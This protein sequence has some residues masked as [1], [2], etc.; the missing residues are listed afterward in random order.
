MFG[1]LELTRLLAKS[2]GNHI[3]AHPHG[4]LPF[5]ETKC[6]MESLTAA[7]R[8]RFADAVMVLGPW[9]PLEEVGPGAEEQGTG[10]DSTGTPTGVGGATKGFPRNAHT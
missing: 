9:R 7:L 5:T 8:K 4:E 10:P 3:A 1:E 2:S 6:G